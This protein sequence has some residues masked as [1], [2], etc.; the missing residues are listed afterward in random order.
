MGRSTQ[1]AC[2]EHHG[3]QFSHSPLA[4]NLSEESKHR[5]KDGASQLFQ[6]V[7]NPLKL[8]A[9]TKDCD[10]T[11]AKMHKFACKYDRFLHSPC[12]S[13]GYPWAP[14]EDGLAQF[15]RDMKLKIETVCRFCNRQGLFAI[16]EASFPQWHWRCNQ[17][18]H[19]ISD[20]TSCQ[21]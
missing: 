5:D 7:K 2:W 16:V 6:R 3:I 4:C 10:A 20:A 12:C 9:K 8:E 15:Q 21:L 14:K 17:K 18:C 11:G 1:I 13:V 19:H